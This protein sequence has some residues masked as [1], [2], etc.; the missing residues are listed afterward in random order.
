MVIEC[1]AHVKFV[2]LIPCQEPV[3][4]RIFLDFFNVQEPKRSSQQWVLLYRA[5][6]LF[7]HFSEICNLEFNLICIAD[8]SPYTCSKHVVCWLNIT[9]SLHVCWEQMLLICL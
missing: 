8:C 2:M 9:M 3:S 6:Q 1:E 4:L 5:R 7:V